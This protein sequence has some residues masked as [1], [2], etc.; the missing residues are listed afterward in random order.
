MEISIVILSCVILGLNPEMPVFIRLIMICNLNGFRQIK[1]IHT[2]HQVL[3]R[4]PCQTKRCIASC[5]C[6]P[7]PNFRDGCRV[8]ASVIAKRL[9]WGQPAVT[10]RVADAADIV[11]VVETIVRTCFPLLTGLY[12]YIHIGVYIARKLNTCAV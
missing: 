4:T 10:P 11:A 3:Q 7:T 1:Y 2:M 5:R 8:R 12:I 9:M 6:Q